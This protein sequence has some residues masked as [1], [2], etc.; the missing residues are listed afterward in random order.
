MSIDSTKAVSV[1][2][3]STGTRPA[4]SPA[5]VANHFLPQ[6]VT[7]T[8]CLPGRPEYKDAADAPANHAFH[9]TLQTIFVERITSGQRS[10]QGG[11]DP[12]KTRMVVCWFRCHS[13]FLSVVSGRMPGS[14]S[15]VYTPPVC[16]SAAIGR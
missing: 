13:S 16:M 12:A 11:H 1:M 9:Q 6:T 10:D 5:D 8:R 14:C 4:T 7:Q 3:T 2:P 15:P